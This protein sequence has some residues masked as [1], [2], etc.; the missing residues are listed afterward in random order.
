M[1]EESLLNSF[2]RKSWE[3]FENRVPIELFLQKELRNIWKMCPNWIVFPDRVQIYLK[4]ESKLILF[5]QKELKNFWKNSP[6]WISIMSIRLSSIGLRRVG[7][8][9]KCST[10]NRSTW[11]SSFGALRAKKAKYCSTSGC[12]N[13]I[14]FSDSVE[15]FLKAE[16]Q[17]NCFFRK[18][19]EIFKK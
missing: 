12:P 18:S 6:I 5:F 15:N 14:S 13:W 10:S 3:I 4:E 2:F 17:L 16:F 8:F 19:S 7:R 9:R 11:P 1:K